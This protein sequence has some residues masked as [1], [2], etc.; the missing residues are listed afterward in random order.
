MQHVEMYNLD[1]AKEDEEMKKSIRRQ[2]YLTLV[3]NYYNLTTDI[4]HIIWGPHYSMGIL[5]PTEGV[6][7]WQTY[8]ACQQMY[9]CY[10]GLSLGANEKMTIGDFG[11]GT[12]GPTRC[13]AQFTG[14]NIKTVNITEYHLNQMKEWNKQEGLS[15][16]IELIHSDYHHTP[17][18]S[19]SLDG[20]YMCESL[21][22]SPDYNM[23]CTEV[24]RVLKPGANKFT[25]F[26]WELTEKFDENNEEHCR[27]RLMIERGVGVPQLVKMCHLT[28]AL[29]QAGFQVLVQ[30]DHSDF[31]EALGGK[32]W[33]YLLE[34]NS[35]SLE[36]VFASTTS[37][38]YWGIWTLE[39]NWHGGTRND[40][41]L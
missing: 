17:I 21:A 7:Q 5:F 10:W 14:A 34:G 20:V 16:R 37:T 2:Q 31:G 18:E 26:N 41:S 36:V 6:N 38:L 15:D 12:G 1:N 19:D 24:F 25:G 40:R 9:Q 3:E 8:P 30:R 33:Y 39:K 22:H 13:I 27:V 32:P 29:E 23:L 4:F 35:T 11:C 28:Q